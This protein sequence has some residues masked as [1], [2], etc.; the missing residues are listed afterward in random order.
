MTKIYKAYIYALSLY[1]VV[2][3]QSSNN[4]KREQQWR[5]KCKRSINFL[6]FLQSTGIYKIHLLR[7]VWFST[8][9]LH[10]NVHISSRLSG[11]RYVTDQWCLIFLQ[12]VSSMISGKLTPSFT[13]WSAS[14]SCFKNALYNLCQNQ[15][16]VSVL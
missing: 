9:D 16:L 1:E 8:A 7:T 2:I 11:V 14:L 13:C 3:I 15:G 6:F 10:I 5:P 4:T 12:E